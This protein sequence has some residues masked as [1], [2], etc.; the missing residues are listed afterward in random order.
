MKKISHSY[1]APYSSPMPF[2]PA[3]DFAQEQVS[4]INQKKLV[5]TKNVSS[6]DQSCVKKNVGWKYCRFGEICI[7]HYVLN[8]HGIHIKQPPN[9]RDTT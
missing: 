3:L 2:W 6:Y 4:Y 8:P 1:R 9:G 7:T 5:E